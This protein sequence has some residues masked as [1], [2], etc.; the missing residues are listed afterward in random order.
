MKR[1]CAGRAGELL[2]AAQSEEQPESEDEAG[3]EPGKAGMEEKCQ[4]V[5]H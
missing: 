5:L 3:Q 2:K 1:N 4:N